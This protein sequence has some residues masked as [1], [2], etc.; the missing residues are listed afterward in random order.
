M[1]AHALVSFACEETS[2]RG[3]LKSFTN[4]SK[5]LTF[6]KKFL[7]STLEKA[8]SA[9]TLPHSL[10]SRLG[11]S[12]LACHLFGRKWHVLARSLP[13]PWPEIGIAIKCLRNTRET[14][15]CSLINSEMISTPGSTTRSSHSSHRRVKAPPVHA[16]PSSTEMN[17]YF[18][19]EQRRQ[20]QAFIDK[21]N[22]DPVNDCPLPGRFE[23][24]KLD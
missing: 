3:P 24:V 10:I 6:R 15:P 14:T 17:E 1:D 13:G 8:P 19:A 12:P 11:L 9:L 7:C 20:Q 5:A 21:Y 18:A 23:W 22:F 4:Q 16:I 2:S